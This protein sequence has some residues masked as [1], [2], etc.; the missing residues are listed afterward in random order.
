MNWYKNKYLKKMFLETTE[1]N[2]AWKKKDDNVYFVLENPAGYWLADSMIFKTESG[3]YLFFE[4]FEKRAGLG[5]LGVMFFKDQIFTDF[6][7]ILKED[8]HLSYPYIFKYNDNFYMIPESR[9]NNTIDLYI[10]RKFPFEWEKV[11]TLAT[12]EYV[13]TSVIQMEGS[14]FLFY[15]YDMKNYQLVKGILDMD[16]IELDLLAEVDDPSYGKRPGGSLYFKKGKLYRPLQNNRYFY[17]QSLSIVEDDTDD[18]KDTILPEN[19]KTN[20]K[21]KYR[22]IHT[23]SKSGD[24]EAIDLSDYRFDLFKVIKRILS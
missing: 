7:I 22:R 8:Y 16:S 4:A 15:T 24:F 20:T 12:G 3:V 2:I 9:G 19:V 14:Q 13:D 21:E 1:W 6:R 10:A 17:G 5:R 23:Y 11:K 18:I